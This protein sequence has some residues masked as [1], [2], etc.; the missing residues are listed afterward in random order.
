MEHRPDPDAGA[1][2]W[3]DYLH[4]R[5]NPAGRTQDLWFHEAG[6]GAWLRVDRDTVTH[7][8]FGAELVGE[9]DAD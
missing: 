7:E 8:I 1:E 6:C 9:R 2:V 3:H 4:L 5:D